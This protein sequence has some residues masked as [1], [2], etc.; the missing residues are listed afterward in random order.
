MRG[1]KGHTHDKIYGYKWGDADLS[2]DIWIA[3]NCI[4]T[5]DDQCEKLFVTGNKN[6]L[7]K[8]IYSLYTMFSINKQ[9]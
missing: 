7:S 4:Y 9:N 2:I 5:L 6:S 1:R 8:R 3:L